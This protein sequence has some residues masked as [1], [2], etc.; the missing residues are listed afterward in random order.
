M[1]NS[2][3]NGIVYWN[4]FIEFC[5]NLDGKKRQIFEHELRRLR[6]EGDETISLHAKK[7]VSVKEKFLWICDDDAK[8]I[9]SNRLKSVD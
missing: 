4:T 5:R 8:M 3:I 7:S 9:Q 1:L 6:R 2:K